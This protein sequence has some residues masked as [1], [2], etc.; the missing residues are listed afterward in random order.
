MWGMREKNKGAYDLPPHADGQVHGQ[1]CESTGLRTS[2]LPQCVDTPLRTFPVPQGGAV[3]RPLHDAVHN[4]ACKRGRGAGGHS[5]LRAGGRGGPG[6]VGMG[7]EG[8]R[9]AWGVA[10]G[11]DG[12]SVVVQQAHEHG[13]HGEVEKL[14]GHVR[15]KRSAVQAIDIVAGLISKSKTDFFDDAVDAKLAAGYYKEGS[16]TVTAWGTEVMHFGIM[17]QRAHDR[18]YDADPRIRLGMIERDFNMM[19]YNALIYNNLKHPV[20]TAAMN[21]WKASRKALA[22]WMEHGESP[23]R[24]CGGEEVYF[25]NPVEI[26]DFCCTGIHQNC[27]REVR[28]EEGYHPLR[29]TDGV[30]D[31]TWFCSDKC[32]EQFSAVAKLVIPHLPEQKQALIASGRTEPETALAFN[33]QDG[34]VVLAKSQSEA[35]SPGVIMKPQTPQQRCDARKNPNVPLVM[36]CQPPQAPVWAIANEWHA[37]PQDWDV[38]AY[39]QQHVPPL[40][41]ARFRAQLQWAREYLNRFWDDESPSASP[42]AKAGGAE[43]KVATED[44]PKTETPRNASS[45]GVVRVGGRGG[46][47]MA[48]GRLD[49]PR[50]ESGSVAAAAGRKSMEDSDGGGVAYM[51][52]SI[53]ANPLTDLNGVETGVSAAALRREDALVGEDHLATGGRGRARD[54]LA[55]VPFRRPG[56]LS[57]ECLSDKVG[58]E[59]RDIYLCGV[60]GQP[61]RGHICPGFRPGGQEADWAERQQLMAKLQNRLSGAGRAGEHSVEV[62]APVQSKPADPGCPSHSGGARAASER[63]GDV[64]AHVRPTFAVSENGG[65][66][67][68]KCVPEHTREPPI[69]AA[70]LKVASAAPES[71]SRRLDGSANEEV[72]RS[73]RENMQKNSLSNLTISRYLCDRGERQAPEDSSCAAQ[74]TTIAPFL[75]AMGGGVVHASAPADRQVEAQRILPDTTGK[76][77]ISLVTA[78][79]VGANDQPSRCTAVATP[80]AGCELRSALRSVFEQP[81]RNLVL[82]PR[83]QGVASSPPP[84]SRPHARAELNPQGDAPRP[85]SAAVTSAMTGPARYPGADLA[86]LAEDKAYNRSVAVAASAMTRQDRR[87]ADVAEVERDAALRER[88]MALMAKAAAESALMNAER[89]RAKG[90]PPTASGP[91]PDCPASSRSAKRKYNCVT[92]VDSHKGRMYKATL[93]VARKYNA[94]TETHVSPLLPNDRLAARAYDLLVAR[95]FLEHGKANLKQRSAVEQDLRLGAI[96]KQDAF[97]QFEDLHQRLNRSRAACAARVN[98]ASDFEGLLE[99]LAVLDYEDNARGQAPRVLDNRQEARAQAASGSVCAEAP[100]GSKGLS[101]LSLSCNSKAGQHA[102]DG[103]APVQSKPADQSCPAHSG[104]ARAA[105]ERIGDVP[106]HVRSTFTWSENGVRSAPPAD[107]Q[108]V[109]QPTASSS[110]MSRT[111]DDG[112]VSPRIRTTNPAAMVHH[113]GALA[114]IGVMLKVVTKAEVGNRYKQ[115]EVTHLQDSTLIDET[116]IEEVRAG[117]HTDAQQGQPVGGQMVVI[118]QILPGGAAEKTK[119][120]QVND[121]IIRI[122]GDVIEGWSLQRIVRALSGVEG[123]KVLLEVRRRQTSQTSLQIELIRSRRDAP[124]AAAA[125]V[126]ASVD[127]PQD[128]AAVDAVAKVNA[129]VTVVG[130]NDPNTLEKVHAGVDDGCVVDAD[131]ATLCVGSVGSSHRVPAVTA[132]CDPARSSAPVLSSNGETSTSDAMSTGRERDEAAVGPTAAAAFSSEPEVDIGVASSSAPERGPEDGN[133]GRSGA[134]GQRSLHDGMD[135]AR[136]PDGQCRMISAGDSSSA[137]QSDGGKGP[138]SSRAPQ[139]DGGK[140][141]DRSSAPQSDGGKGAHGPSAPQSD[142][143][144]EADRSSG[145]QSDS[146]K[147]AGKGGGKGQQLQSTASDSACV[148]GEGQAHLAVLEARR[149]I[150]VLRARYCES[151]K[152]LEPGADPAVSEGVRMEEAIEQLHP[153]AMLL[154]EYAKALEARD[155]AARAVDVEV[156][157]ERN[158]ALR[159]DRT[160]A[161]QTL[162]AMMP[163][164]LEY[165][166]VRGRYL[167]ALQTISMDEEEEEAQEVALDAL[168]NQQQALHRRLKQSFAELVAR[169]NAAFAKA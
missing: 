125:G 165:K 37:L 84:Q 19:I 86:F 77:K 149:K 93:T 51:H 14:S 121:V 115:G 65:E 156:S 78:V 131:K 50:T 96:S 116:G 4:P 71:T 41:H 109:S 108:H 169:S 23:C 42:Q 57:H 162:E 85:R 47:G 111:V 123:S 113:K 146:G 90:V 132:G 87:R 9:T 102:V 1:E 40:E 36:W 147:G 29:E 74:D 48:A 30:P 2:P 34:L 64:P 141:S 89:E 56:C 136:L 137:P 130:P 12:F 16:T 61:K 92:A 33:L 45:E 46:V 135:P 44:G 7:G 15:Q 155:K 10:D 148:A 153:L 31:S 119:L 168:C 103:K 72:L 69:A 82:S 140:G 53:P 159:R 75:A 163:V 128:V 18:I 11:A 94:A 22:S 66:A 60:C 83:Q 152:L 17:Q 157:R 39:V 88:D 154:G 49:S 58:G 167:E 114:T 144:K 35:L 63:I 104:G 68:R 158:D 38:D 129:P 99:T 161:A 120:L 54:G 100:D 164:A 59:T 151:L 160:I 98:F 107:I 139:N 134:L 52:T 25:E 55:W 138:N 32:K 76:R 126:N 3:K 6:G 101:N 26:C 81:T 67:N 73:G 145:P 142:G 13:Q 133:D 91:V 112:V 118:T 122:D 95:S 110:A 166:A 150:S 80:I 97:A 43:D 124:V 70:S 127:P 8:S 106:A 21:L 79:P 20:H 143:G 117:S 105:S 24:E 62:K 27:Q 5:P 28:K